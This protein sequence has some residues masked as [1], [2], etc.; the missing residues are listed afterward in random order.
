MSGTR[1]RLALRALG[2]PLRRRLLVAGLSGTVGAILVTLGAAAWLARLG[3]LRSPAWVLGAWVLALVAAASIGAGSASAHPQP[4]GKG[5]DRTVTLSAQLD[6]LTAQF[7]DIE[8]EFELRDIVKELRSDLREADVK[9]MRVSLRR[10]RGNVAE[11]HIA[12]AAAFKQAAVE[13][14]RAYQ[15]MRRDEVLRSYVPNFRL[16]VDTLESA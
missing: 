16:H 3:V 13:L 14:A 5:A 11:I 7:D 2:T 12:V 8:D 4:S 1:T 9:P 15:V 10:R 6:E